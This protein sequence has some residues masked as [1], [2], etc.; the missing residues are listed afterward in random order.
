M[1]FKRCSSIGG[2][3]SINKQRAAQFK[4]LK[5]AWKNKGIIYIFLSI[6]YIHFHAIAWE[7][8]P[9]PAVFKAL[10]ELRVLKLIKLFTASDFSCFN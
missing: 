6:L 1:N 8:S 10:I 2:N 9:L 5:L 3:K 4:V 7:N